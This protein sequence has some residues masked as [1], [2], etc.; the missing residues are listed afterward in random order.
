MQAVY[1]SGAGGQFSAQEIGRRAYTAPGKH[2]VGNLVNRNVVIR[3]SQRTGEAVEMGARAGMALD[4]LSRAGQAGRS[5]T[6]EGATARINRI[7]FNYSQVSSLDATMRR[8]IPFWTFMSRNVPLQAQMMYTNPRA[9]QHY[10]SFARNFTD[11]NQDQSALPEWMQQ[12]GAIRLTGATALMPDVGATQFE[13]QVKQLTTPSRLL[14]AMGP[15]QKVPLQL[16]TNRNFFYDSPYRENDFVKTTGEL[17]PLG[18][19]AEMLGGGKLPGGGE[20]IPRK[21]ADAL[22]SVLPTAGQINRV[23]GTSPDQEAKQAYNIAN[24]MLG[25]PVRSTSPEVLQK[26]Q[27]RRQRKGK[28]DTAADQARLDALRRL[29]AS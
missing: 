13:D 20:A 23:G 10:R 12:G 17:A 18:P 15:A 4:S 3:G 14:S 29:A 8:I 25:I 5:G 26:E 22:R 7:H 6:L 21:W 1:N 19:L 11:E 2:K 28:T 16:I 27:E 24:L 9:Y